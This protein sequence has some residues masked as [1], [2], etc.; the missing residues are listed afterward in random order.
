MK[1][2]KSGLD[3]RQL[4]TLIT[5]TNNDFSVSRTADKLFLVQS[6]VSQQIKRME[7]ELDVELFTRKG[8]RLTGLTEFGKQVE[9]QAL[10]AIHSINNIH[11]IAEDEQRLRQG[12]L[13]IGCTHTQ[14]RYILPPVINQFYRKYPDVELQMHQG[15]PQQLVE[16]AVNDI[17]DF[18][19]CTEELG[20]AE[21]LESIPCYRWNRCLIAQPGHPV[22]K[23]KQP[24]LEDL[25]DYPIIT[26]VKG[27]TGRENLDETFR[28]AQLRPNMV[29]SAADTDI[30]KTYVLDGMGIGI[31]ASMAYNEKVD[32]SLHARDLSKLFPWEVTR[33][34]Y[35][36]NKYIRHHEQEFISLFQAS[37]RK[38]KSPGVMAL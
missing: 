25:C 26:Y 17:V 29:L 11:R 7:Q 21:R 24:G 15:T 28:Q 32:K 6:A 12:V 31:I 10:N 34:A 22:L 18:S 38:D 35:L 1:R 27:F 19:I 36:K 14:A 3:L 37:V 9:E 16:W 4:H 2:Y 30:I 13:R 23:Q 8:K 20:Q 5:L 33:I